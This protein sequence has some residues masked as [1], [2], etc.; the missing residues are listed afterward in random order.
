MTL[1]ENIIKLLDPEIRDVITKLNELSLCKTLYS[2]SGHPESNP[3]ATP[4]V[5][6]RY[7]PERVNE[8]SSFHKYL[9]KEVPYLSFRVLPIKDRNK[10]FEDIIK[11]ENHRFH[12]IMY[13]EHSRKKV[14]QFWE[15]W[16]RILNSYER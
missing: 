9:M 12:Y 10:D 4:Y 8:A 1:D 3:V 6:I 2:C 13:G 7:N 16:R 11:D 14:N 15:G 5:D